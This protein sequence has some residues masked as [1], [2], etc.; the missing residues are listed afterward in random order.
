MI[1]VKNITSFTTSPLDSFGFS[2]INQN[3]EL[4]AL[5]ANESTYFKNY[6]TLNNIKDVSVKDKT[7]IY[8]TDQI[9]LTDSIKYNTVQYPDFHNHLTSQ[10]VEYDNCLI[11][12]TSVEEKT[13]TEYSDSQ[14]LLFCPFETQK[15][16]N[17]FLFNILELKNT[18][19][20][21]Y[22]YTDEIV[23][24]YDSISYGNNQ[25]KNQGNMVLVSNTE[26]D[27]TTFLPDKKTEFTYDISLVNSNLTE[28]IECGAIG[29][30][31]PNNSDVIWVS[32]YGYTCDPDIPG[33]NDGNYIC[34]WLSANETLCGQTS[35]AWMD[36]K[37]D[38]TN[39]SLI[40][41]EPSTTL[42]IGGKTY[43]Y[44][45]MGEK[46]N[47]K[48]IQTLE[49][50]ATFLLSTDEDFFP[51]DAKDNIN[52][53]NNGVLYSSE[54]FLFDG[55]SYLELQ[56]NELLNQLNSFTI[57]TFIKKEKWC[58]GE[59]GQ[60]IGNYYKGG[61]G[62]FYN[63]GNYSSII[64]FPTDSGLIYGV[65]SDTFK[66]FE[67]NLNETLTYD[68][69]RIT[70]IQTDTDLARWLMDNENH[71]IY[72][73]DIDNVIISQI[74]LASNTD[75]G[76]MAINPSNNVLNIID[77]QNH[78][79]SSFN[80]DGTVRDFT[81]I[82]KKIN[83]VS[84]DLN[85]VRNLDTATKVL[86]DKDNNKI[87]ALGSSIYRNDERI[88]PVG[89][90]I[91]DILIDKNNHIWITEESNIVNIINTNGL[92]IKRIEMDSKYKS[93]PEKNIVS[94]NNYDSNK[95]CENERIWIIGN[96]NKTIT[97]YDLDGN[98]IEEKDLMKILGK[99]SCFTLG[100]LVLKGDFSGYDIN[101]RLNIV[102]SEYISTKNPTIT[103]KMRIERVGTGS[104]C[105]LD[106]T[107]YLHYPICHFDKNNK[108]Y[109]IAITHDHQTKEFRL[110][111]DGEITK[112]TT[113]NYDYVLLNNRTTPYIV[114]G[115]S[116][117]INTE[118]SER[119]RTNGYFVGEL[120][121]TSIYDNALSSFDIL[122]LSNEKEKKFE[123]LNWIRT[124][125]KKIKTEM[126]NKYH[127]MNLAGL[128]SNTFNIRIKNFGDV[129]D[130]LKLYIES[131]I[132]KE[133]AKI[134]P[135][136]TDVNSIIWE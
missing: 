109:H 86:Y 48:N 64:T 16:E 116:G 94:V 132:L 131:Q 7:L 30:S 120:Y 8:L 117:K 29:G 110:L 67:K 53:I 82:S 9:D 69:F 19:V 119:G 136:H 31:S 21:N 97:I 73:L 66:I 111:V 96:C 37:F 72:K 60:I 33:E 101:R 1:T 121:K 38:T 45:R 75:I 15:T 113:I 103:A 24:I 23:N 74:N 107:I 54:S 134:K 27:V 34:S 90:R 83:Y 32:N 46:K 41:D 36:R 77:T 68:D 4:S 98:F 3:R 129:S 43:I 84:F 87:K 51:D 104:N 81:N 25:L 17:D 99:G 55:N 92:L 124:T 59:N 100:N 18:A 85:N 123:E 108:D 130:D 71:K 93:D 76:C 105:G 126:I 13:N 10:Y 52:I 35:Y 95:G 135:S 89:N 102:D 127:I 80:P 58:C 133:I 128:K 56:N 11:N 112:K 5:S 61:K 6:L 39:T 50:N 20:N 2:Y 114:G 26:K 115:S 57:S 118:N 42:L 106:A 122:S 79:L 78:R 47:T 125:D 49:S 40:Y 65:N 28:F 22:H 91:V 62:I 88:Y 63:T 14:F 44:E 70:E 12:S